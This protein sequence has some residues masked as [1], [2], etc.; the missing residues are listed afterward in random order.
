MHIDCRCWQQ[1]CP[2]QPATCLLHLQ[3]DVGFFPSPPYLL[4]RFSNG[5]VW[6]ELVATLTG[7]GLENLATGNA[8]SGAAQGAFQILPPFGYLT[9][10]GKPLCPILKE[11]LLSGCM[12][13][14]MQ[15]SL[16]NRS[17]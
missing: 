3:V 9:Q 12:H 5:P 10:T 17:L 8:P 16:F 1:Q 2:S 7:N 6:I 11:H 13:C 14:A 4:G 15:P